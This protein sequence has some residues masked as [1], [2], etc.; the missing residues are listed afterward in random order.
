MSETE[1]QNT[2]RGRVVV[3]GTD[4]RKPPLLDSSEPQMILVKDGFGDPMALLVRILS[5]DTWGLCTKGDPDWEA[6]LIKYGFARVRPDTSARDIIV[7]GAGP[8]MENI[9]GH[10]S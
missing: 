8:H 5:D 3:Y 9:H 2:N 4:I 6:M 1:N 10:E 7:D